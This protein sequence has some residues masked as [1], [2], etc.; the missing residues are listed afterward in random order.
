MDSII[1]AGRSL[2]QAG[3]DPDTVTNLFG[4][5]QYDGQCEFFG[6]RAPLPVRFSH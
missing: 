4:F 1:N 2:S 5:T 6:G 3:C